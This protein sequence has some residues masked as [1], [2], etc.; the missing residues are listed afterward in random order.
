MSDVI[1]QLDALPHVYAYNADGT[2]NT[3]TVTHPDGSVWRK[4]YTWTNGRLTAE[5]AWVKQ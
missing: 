3:D 1:F 4:T 5:S 2:I